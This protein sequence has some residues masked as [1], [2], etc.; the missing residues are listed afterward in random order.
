MEKQLIKSEAGL[1]AAVNLPAARIDSVIAQRKCIMEAVKGAMKDNVHFGK[2]PGCGDKPTMFKPG[3]EVLCLLF[4]LRPRFDSAEH[5]RGNGHIEVIDTCSLYS[6]HDQLMGQGIG[7]CS[8]L[9]S[10][11]RYRNA[12]RKCPECGKETI[13][14]G[15]DNYGGGWICFGKKGGCGAKFPDGA[16]EIEK[17]ELGKV[18]NPDVADVYNTVRKMAKKRAFVDAALTTTGASEFFTQD[19]DDLPEY[20]TNMIQPELGPQ[21]PAA[22]A[23]PLNSWYYNI[24]LLD[25][26]GKQEKAEEYAR[27]NGAEYDDEWNLWLSEIELS[28][29]KKCFVG[30]NRPA[31]AGDDKEG[32]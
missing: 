5:D 28:K 16:P 32:E 19:F 22:T 8:T 24:E 9:E 15:K 7:S 23:T 4:G 18:D 1:V 21:G 6:P 3:A 2:I 10:K 12:A 27:A 13:I 11:Y 29:L 14:K 26:M 30:H 17:Q 31:V 25:D 20:V